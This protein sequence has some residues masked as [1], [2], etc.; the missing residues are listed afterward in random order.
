ME[1]DE[2]SAALPPDPGAGQVICHG[3]FGPWNVVWDGLTPVGLVDFDFAHP[4]PALDDVA[5]ALEYTAPFRDD[6][7]A[8]RWQGFDAPPDRA[9]RVEIVAEEY[10]LSTVEGLVDAVIRHQ[11]LT[12]S[13]VRVL[14]EQGLEPQRT[15]VAEGYGDEM[16]ARTQWSRDNRTL[17]QPA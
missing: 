6:A 2:P 14:A 13:H 17:F 12:S 10:G 11:E 3:D 9:R 7:Q 5:Y 8:M 4:G 16:A 15:W 1:T